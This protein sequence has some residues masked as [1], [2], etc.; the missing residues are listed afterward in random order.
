MLCTESFVFIHVPKTGGMSVTRFLINATD[1]PVSV[2][3]RERGRQH[4]FDM[5]ITPDRAE[6]LNYVAGNR[7]ATP[8]K[9]IKMIREMGLPVPS[10]GFCVIR[11]PIDLMISYYK[12]MRK[13]WV[14]KSR[15]LDRDSLTG[16]LKNAVEKDFSHFCSRSLFYGHDDHE[17]SEFYDSN[18]ID[19]LDIVPLN[20][21]SSYLQVSFGDS[22]NF[23]EAELEHRNKSSEDWGRK[24][25]DE[26][27]QALIC[28]RYPSILKLYQDAV[29]KYA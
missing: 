17:L 5:A 6:K 18:P 29:E 19:R 3:G 25:V 28:S 11:H 1:E 2:F 15:G 27:S 20:R 7:H 23:S 16:D 22:R 4:C 26:K 13:P 21:I 8:A 24:D 9:G 14:W 12:H 10:W